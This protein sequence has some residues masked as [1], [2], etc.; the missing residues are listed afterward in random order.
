MKIIIILFQLV[1]EYR[2]KK[3]FTLTALP[4]LSASRRIIL[5]RR[6]SMPATRPLTRAAARR[7]TAEQQNRTRAV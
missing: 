7:K 6:T 5:I 4:M 1:G 2:T 3:Y